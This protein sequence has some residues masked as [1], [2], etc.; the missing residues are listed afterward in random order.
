M[1]VLL[2]PSSIIGTNQRAV[3]LGSNHEPGGQV[4]GLMASV[5][6]GLTAQDQYRLQR[7]TF[8]TG[9]GLPLPLPLIYRLESDG[10]LSWHW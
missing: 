2:S 6:C 4:G 8:C 7:P 10:M 5:T 1:R 9:G 3:M